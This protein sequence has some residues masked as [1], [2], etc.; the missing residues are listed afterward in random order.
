MIDRA[1]SWFAPH[2]CEGCGAVGSTLCNRCNKDILATL[3]VRCVQ[4]LRPIDPKSRS[5]YGVICIT[6]RRQSPFARVYVVGERSGA[7]QRLIGNFKY[8][9]RRD[10]A[11]SIARLLSATLPN[12]LPDGMNIVFAPTSP[13][14]IRE[15]GFDHMRLVAKELGKQR[16]LPVTPIIRRINN[17]SQHS[18]S[19]ADRIQQIRAAFRIDKLP[20]S[21]K[22]LL[23]DDI[24]TT[25]ATVRTIAVL[26][27]QAGAKE[28]WLAVVARQRPQ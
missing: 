16:N 1:I 5:L 14:H 24:Y 2:I 9:S 21:K 19:R 22:V 20:V 12:R 18:A 27:K 4:C 17:Q 8:F 13:K 3:W 6:C 25:G 7:L 23:I 28:I 15:R 11:R 10:S 26:L